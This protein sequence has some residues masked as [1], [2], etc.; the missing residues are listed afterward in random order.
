MK[1]SIFL[2]FILT[3]IGEIFSQ[4][5]ALPPYATKFTWRKGNTFTTPSQEESRPF[6]GPRARHSVATFN[7]MGYVFGGSFYLFYI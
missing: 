5:N 2:F 3:C 7:D 4:E 6:P 1:R